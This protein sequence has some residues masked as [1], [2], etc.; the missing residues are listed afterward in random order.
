MTAYPTNPWDYDEARAP[1]P[2]P[3]VEAADRAF[4]EAN[5]HHA[6]VVNKARELRV[7]EDA[8]ALL[9]LEREGHVDYDAMFLNR[10]QLRNLPEPEPLIERILPRH[11]YAILRGRDQSFKSFVA[12]DWALCVA[13]GKHWMRHPTEQGRVLYIAGEGVEGLSKRI[14]AWET[15]W[16]TTVDPAHF[17]TRRQALDLHRP[18][19]AFDHL[20]GQVHAD[21]YSLVVVDTLRRVSGAADGNSSEMGAVVDNLDRIK[22]ATHRG[23]VL[24]VAH[25][26]KDDKDSRG[27][28]G[29]ED[30]AD[31]V[32]SAKRDEMQL[33]LELRKNKDGADG[34]TFRLEAIP[35]MRSL[36]I[37]EAS[38]RSPDVS[39]AHQLQVLE[40]L[41]TTY[42]DGAS[43][44][45]LI[46][47]TG[48]SKATLHRALNALED[49]GHVVNT[50]TKRQKY[51]EVP[52]MPET[53]DPTS[54]D[55]EPDTPLED[56]Q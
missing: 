23:S 4:E 46:E 34:H 1:H 19:P 49:A 37:A 42:R 50:G 43:P 11:C 14:E 6:A 27:Y 21:G 33:L 44:T 15:G 52:P 54:H 31:V 35:T 12:L 25:T 7:H 22:Q 29:I 13:T 48:I 53:P 26:G 45:A 10:D 8:R 5:R 38:D 9:R 55:P 36:T 16:A 56:P 41:Q 40:V 51:F 47:A 30:D 18:G 32:W 3:E 2:D 39:N 17:V 20:L 28:S 24:V